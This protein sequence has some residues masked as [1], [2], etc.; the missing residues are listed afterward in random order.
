M[1]AALNIDRSV[2]G[3][4][5]RWRR[6]PD[7]S[8]G[9]DA[10]IDELLLARGIERDDLARHRDPR[11]R[12]FLP[13]PSCFQDMEK[14]AKRLADAVQTGESIA[15][16]GDYDVDGATSAALLVLLLRR[17]GT[18]PMVYIPDRLMEGYGPSGAALVELKRRGASL[19]VTVDCGAQ[20]FEAL[21]EARAAGLDVIVVDHHQCASALPA[22]YALINP[23]RLDESAD[24]AA[25]GHLAA[26]GVAFLL[27]VALI[28]ELRGRGYFDALA[29]PKLLDLLDVVALGTVADVA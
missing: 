24:G 6:P 27:G 28:R 16:F 19:A 5:W 4:P 13:D 11:I 10:L 22:A 3:Q 18:D 12:D 2:S 8:L 21:E 9:M 25:H 14:G 29:E 7:D 26:V 20:A 15:I 17:L 1:G 23:N